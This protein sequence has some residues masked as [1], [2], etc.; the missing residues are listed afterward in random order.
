[1]TGFLRFGVDIRR[2]SYLVNDFGVLKTKAFEGI[3]RSVIAIL[4]D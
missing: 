4:I 2:V 3:H 1:M